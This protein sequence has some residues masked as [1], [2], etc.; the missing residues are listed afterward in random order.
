MTG[1]AQEKMKKVIFST[2][3]EIVDEKIPIHEYMKENL[4]PTTFFHERYFTWD[5]AKI[6]QLENGEPCSRP[7]CRNHISHPCEK[8]GR[9]GAHGKA[10]VVEEK[11]KKP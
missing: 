2:S 3:S 1:N 9:F 5:N 7:G 4:S 10:T 6:I 8:C 11:G